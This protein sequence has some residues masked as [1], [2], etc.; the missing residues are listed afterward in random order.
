M[1]KAIIVFDGFCNF[2][3]RAVDVI[4]RADKENKFLFVA[5][6]SVAGIK[7]LQQYGV[8]ELTSVCLIQQ[9]KV[10]VKSEACIEIAKSLSVPLRWLK[11]FDILPF[12]FRDAIY[13]FIAHR[14]YKWFGKK[15]H[16]KLPSE[17]YKVK[18]IE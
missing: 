2:C 13:T 3:S 18:F 10:F 15:L 5:S 1:D 7:L 11:F 14:R 8:E 17:K 12:V 16:C 4:I 6:Q 9:A